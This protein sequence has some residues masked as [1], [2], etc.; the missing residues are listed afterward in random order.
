MPYK[1]LVNSMAL[2]N[3]SINI[4]SFLCIR[5]TFNK[6]IAL[7]ISYYTNY[8]FNI[9]ITFFAYYIFYY[10]FT[11]IKNNTC[12]LN[13]EALKYAITSNML[14]KLLFGFVTDYICISYKGYNWYVFNISDFLITICILNTVL[15]YKTCE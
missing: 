14:D 7:C 4:H 9:F 13:T 12:K 15:C 1:F 2:Y 5:L 3:D 8:Y 10:I 11:C 6:G